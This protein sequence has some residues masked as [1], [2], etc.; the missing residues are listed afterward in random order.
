MSHTPSP[1]TVHSNS[2]KFPAAGGGRRN[3]HLAHLPGRDGR[4][5]RTLS[6]PIVPPPQLLLLTS[7]CCC[8]LFFCKGRGLFSTLTHKHLSILWHLHTHFPPTL[9]VC[10]SYQISLD[11][12]SGG[13][14]SQTKIRKKEIIQVLLVFFTR[15]KKLCIKVCR[16]IDSGVT[17]P[18][19]PRRG[20][21]CV[22]VTVWGGV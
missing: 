1:D 13:D 14:I 11:G 5:K 4:I 6:L 16:V 2:E 9:S 7:C 20:G 22:K 3:V 8:W 10:P 17:K 18:C 15:T 19:R 21:G 12:H